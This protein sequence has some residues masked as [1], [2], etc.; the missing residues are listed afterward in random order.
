MF[1]VRKKSYSWMFVTI[2]NRYWNSVN[3]LNVF[4]RLLETI[5][6]ESMWKYVWI[7]LGF[8]L[9]LVCFSRYIRQLLLVLL[10]N[11][12][13]SYLLQYRG[14]TRVTKFMGSALCVC[15]FW[16]LPGVCWCKNQLQ[17]ANSRDVYTFKI[18]KEYNCFC[19]TNKKCTDDCKEQKTVNATF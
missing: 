8:I 1:V 12:V 16:P 15:K 19:S 4:R 9:C 2:D 6:Y 10:D 14:S 5:E 7:Y 3:I 13:I 11:A 18:W 17:C